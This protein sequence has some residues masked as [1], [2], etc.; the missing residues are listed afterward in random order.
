LH[1]CCQAVLPAPRAPEGGWNS[2]LTSSLSK[3]IGFELSCFPPRKNSKSTLTPNHFFFKRR[4]TIRFLLR[5]SGEGAIFSISHFHYIELLESRNYRNV[6]STRVWDALF[7]TTQ[8]TRH[9][10]THHDDHNTKTKNT[11]IMRG[12]GRRLFPWP[13]LKHCEWCTEPIPTW[14]LQLRTPSERI[15]LVMRRNPKKLFIFRKK[16]WWENTHTRDS[17]DNQYTHP[18]FNNNEGCMWINFNI[19][20]VPFLN[21]FARFLLQ[22]NSKRQS[23]GATAYHDLGWLERLLRWHIYCHHGMVTLISAN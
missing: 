19:P 13:L 12:T 18:E 15:N 17:D 2:I 20:W 14:W 21:C 1:F 23:L 5:L 7:V 16:V 11:D 6:R 9:T 8:S 3:T 10:H 22:I 4:W